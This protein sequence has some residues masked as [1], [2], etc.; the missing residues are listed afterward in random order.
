MSNKHS[1]ITVTRSS[2]AGTS[3]VKDA[4]EHIF[5]RVGARAAT[6]EGDSFHRFNRQ[7]MMYAM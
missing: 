5:R 7:E 4:L 1:I 2:G 3:T 6:I